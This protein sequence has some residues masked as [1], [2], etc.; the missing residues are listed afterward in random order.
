MNAKTMTLPL[1]VALVSGMSQA[2][3][4]PVLAPE[5]A[6]FAVLGAS[7]VTNTGATELIGNLGV[8]PGSAIT[9]F[10]GTLENDGPGTFT[11]APHQADAFAGTAHIQLANMKADLGLLGPLKWLGAELGGLTL[12]PGIYSVLAGGNLTGTLTLDGAGDANAFWVFLVPSTLITAAGSVVDVIHAGAGAGLYWNVGSSA[13]LGAN[14]TFEGNIL[15]GASISM[16]D[17]VTLSCGRALAHTG[18][19]TMIHDT[20]NSADCAGTG[21]EG[22]NGLNGGVSAVVPEPETYALMLAGLGALC[23]VARGRRPRATAR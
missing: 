4:A 23:L 19:V 7:T 13:T 5:L 21:E 20:V 17:G 14:S 11:G 12:A 3:A 8:S 6:S 2:W 1:L 22:S 15:A 18:A 9:G 16:G 10:F